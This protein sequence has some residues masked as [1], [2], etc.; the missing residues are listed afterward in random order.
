MI[1]WRLV[2]KGSVASIYLPSVAAADV[3]ALAAELYTRHDLILAD[4]HTL[5]CHTGG[6]T[7]VPIPKGSD[8][9]FAGLLSIEFPLGVRRGQQFDIVVRQVTTAGARIRV[10]S[11]TALAG[12]DEPTD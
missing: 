12:T 4:P 6:I 10:G 2:P 8:V 5:R 7:Y 3:L 11:R 9:N 1:D